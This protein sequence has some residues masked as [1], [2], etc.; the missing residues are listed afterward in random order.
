MYL[1]IVIFK[2]MGATIEPR[3]DNRQQ[4]DLEITYQLLGRTTGEIHWH[5]Q[6]D[7]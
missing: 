1:I 3:N 6:T 4:A 2:G 7:L 5:I